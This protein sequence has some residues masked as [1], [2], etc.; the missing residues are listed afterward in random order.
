MIYNYFHKVR[1]RPQSTRNKTGWEL[2]RNTGEWS[3][4]LALLESALQG[5]DIQVR[6]NALDL[7]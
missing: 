2:G 1:L 5:Y 7:A 4:G 3:I 6:G